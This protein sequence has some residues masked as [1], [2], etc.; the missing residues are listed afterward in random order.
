MQQGK[1]PSASRQACSRQRAGN[2]LASAIGIAAVL[3]VPA[4][5]FAQERRA[6]T[7]EEIVVTATRR[8]QSLQE[9]PLA[10]SA[11]SS[12]DL[13]VRGVNALA[14]IQPG[15]I[16]GVNFTSFTN[17]PSMLQVAIRGNASPDGTQGTTEL[18][19]PIYIDGVF[20]GRSQ[21]SGLELIDPER[22][23]ILRGPQ[24]QLFG[25]NAEG[26]AVQYVS[27][28]PTGELGVRA[29]ASVGNYNAQTYSLAV[30]LPKIAGISATLSGIS[31]KHDG[32]TE[33]KA[34]PGQSY[35]P[36]SPTEDFSL[37]DSQGYRIALRWQ[38]ENENV[39]VDYS[40]DDTDQEDSQP[41]T[42][43]IPVNTGLPAV[44]E[45]LPSDDY[46]DK[47]A[48]QIH[49]GKYDGYARGH[50]LTLGW[51][52][53]EAITLKSITAYRESGR[54]GFTNLGPGLPAPVPG[55]YFV[56]NEQVDAEQTSQELQFIGTWKQF[57]LTAGAIY[58]NEEVSDNRLGALSGPFIP[59]VFGTDPF[60]VS[61]SRQQAE[62]DSYGLYAQGSYRPT[63]FEERLEL[64]LGLRYSDDSKKALRTFDMGA[65]GP[66]HI[67]STFEEERVDP[68]FTVRYQ[69]TEDLN[70][71][72]RYATGYRAGGSNIRSST[73]TSFGAEE[74]EQWELGLKSQWADGS[75]QLNM[76]IY[77]NTI[78]DEQLTIQEDPIENPSL[79]NTIN[80]AVDKKV[81]GVEMELFWAVTDRLDLGVNF[82]YMDADDIVD[83]VN[84]FDPSGNTV[85]R[86]WVI[87]TPENSGSVFANYEQPLP[88]GNLKF[89]VSYAWSD[90]FYATPGAIN[91]ATLPADFKRPANDSS[92]LAA[93]LAWQA[94]P[95]GEG[96]IDIALWGKNLTDDAG[97]VYGYDGCASGGGFCTYRTIPRTY[98]LEVRYNY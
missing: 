37:L 27:R 24:G 58:Y 5:V 55:F 17:V 65:G 71:Y 35:V 12:D 80:S 31:S 90:D 46:P 44:S 48:M 78:K 62:T 8:E 94:I 13:T 77:H 91:L 38:S 25:R 75:V 93:R 50:A 2:A 76:A 88:V 19:V 97:I 22:I 40:H 87:Q 81:K 7:I 15:S 60:V 28:K 14:D 67:P 74:S 52:V 51:Q 9:V 83:V 54:D 98:G 92:Q 16:P 11:L 68:A 42:G 36:P 4:E 43:W 18:P 53:S 10:V 69:W 1:K 86:F 33:N 57:D 84:P 41:Y 26:G 85:N 96:G 95:V 23:E 32:Y 47:S 66:V 59:F 63:A 45:Q 49:S 73:F 89:H 70:T 34:S 82:S 56:A 3:C 79:T 20:L 30:D 21:G 72:L 64:I 6:G 61:D 39:T 29:R